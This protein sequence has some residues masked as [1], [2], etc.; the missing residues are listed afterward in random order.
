[1]TGGDSESLIECKCLICCINF[2]KK[3]RK[4]SVVA[5]DQELKRIYLIDKKKWLDVK[6]VIQ[7]EQFNYSL[8]KY[9]FL[10]IRDC[11]ITYYE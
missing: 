6:N 4:F 8:C 5:V 7:A 11:K 3:K 9:S 10:P 1:M 2:K